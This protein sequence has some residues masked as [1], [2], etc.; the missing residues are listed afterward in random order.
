MRTQG[1]IQRP[2]EEGREAAFSLVEL[3]LAVSLMSVIVFGLYSM[4][5]ETQ[6][7]LRSNVRQVDVLE[8]GRAAIELLV[9]DLEQASS[10][11][12][13]VSP[14]PYYKPTKANTKMSKPTT[15]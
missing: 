14:Q 4:F 1:V 5:N 11:G 8:A 3:L 6:K 7:A 12:L 10:P 13:P 2:K 9:S 15:A